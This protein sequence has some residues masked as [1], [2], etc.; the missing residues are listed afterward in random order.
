MSEPFAYIL[1]RWLKVEYVYDVFHTKE[2]PEIGKMFK[3]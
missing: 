3:K 1:D 2:I